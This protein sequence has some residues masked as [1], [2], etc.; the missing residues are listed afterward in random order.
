MNSRPA[1]MCNLKRGNWAIVA[2]TKIVDT[3]LR[4][5]NLHVDGYHT[6]FVGKTQ[7]WVHNACPTDRYKDA[8]DQR[9]LDA[10]RRESKGEVVARK[11]DGT[12]Y[13]NITEVRNAQQSLQNRIGKIKA[14]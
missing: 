14:R 1:M 11:L 9:H 3:P 5:Y 6:Y 4:A 13:N 7:A 2:A 12:P 8:L 10:A